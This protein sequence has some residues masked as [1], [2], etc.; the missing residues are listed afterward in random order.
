Q[1]ERRL[2]AADDAV[3]DRLAERGQVA[4]PL[5]LLE[6]QG[7]VAQRPPREQVEAPPPVGAGHLPREARHDLERDLSRQ[8]S[9]DGGDIHWITPSLFF[10]VSV[11]SSAS[12]FD[13]RR[14]PR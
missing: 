8:G 6:A 9:L 4:A 10:K 11:T 12:A 14:V 2:E 3:R 7:H 1:P 5:L 13:R